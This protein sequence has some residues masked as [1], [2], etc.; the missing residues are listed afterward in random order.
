MFC[1]R[2]DYSPAVVL[3]LACTNSSSIN[4]H[5]HTHTLIRWA[6]SSTNSASSYRCMTSP[7]NHSL[8]Q[9]KCLCHQKKNGSSEGGGERQGKKMTEK[10][11]RREECGCAVAVLRV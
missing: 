3:T 1:G 10:R 11:K 9:T 2:P 8:R 6:L 4:T 5:T 7:G